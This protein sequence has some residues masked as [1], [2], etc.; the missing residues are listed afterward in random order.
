MARLWAYCRVSTADQTHENQIHEKLRP[1]V[2][3]LN[4]GV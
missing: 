4:L 2:S 1:L 3:R